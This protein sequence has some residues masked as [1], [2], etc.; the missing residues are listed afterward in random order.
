MDALSTIEIRVLGCLLEKAVTTPDQYPLTIN[1]II[2]ASN[3]KSS[4]DPVMNLAQGEVQRALRLLEDKLLASTEP[5]LRGRVEKYSQRF[6]KTPFGMYELD[7]G[8][9]AVLTVL[10]LR[11]PQTPG[12]LKT[13]CERMH[14]FNGPAAVEQTLLSLRDWEGGALVA[15][16]PREP[17]RR[18]ACWAQ[19]F[20]EDADAYRQ[21]GTT[22]N[23]AISA[24]AGHTNA[25][26]ATT[27]PEPETVA[28]APTTSPSAKTGN[29]LDRLAA[30]EARVAS[31]ELA[32]QK[33]QQALGE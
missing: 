17:N 14:S 23:A 16:Q 31:L 26:P 25:E 33:L 4:R 9:Y 11:G 24:T 20:G 10:M 1:A 7:T 18:D 30:L 13:R 27:T 29:G 28:I 15:E 2:S 6:C 12:E 21:A 5:N 19:L 22:N 32:L 8:Q 3:Q